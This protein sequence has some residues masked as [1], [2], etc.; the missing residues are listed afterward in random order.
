MI[1]WL[2]IAL[3]FVCS[4]FSDSCKINHKKFWVS[5]VT[6]VWKHLANFYLTTYLTQNIPTRFTKQNPN[7]TRT[8]SH[9]SLLMLI[10]ITFYKVYLSLNKLSCY[11]CTL[12]MYVYMV[13]LST[14]LSTISLSSVHIYLNWHGNTATFSVCAR[15]CIA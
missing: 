2:R 6:S 15:N 9:P 7:Q 8:N 4:M 11:I 10:F 1:I 3:I 13:G 12:T 14:Y 5:F